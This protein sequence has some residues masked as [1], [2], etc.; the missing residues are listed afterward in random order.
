MTRVIF[1]ACRYVLTISA[2][3]LNQSCFLRVSVTF[4]GRIPANGSVA[5]KILQEPFRTFFHHI[6]QLALSWPE[7]EFCSSRSSFWRIRPYKPPCKADRTVSCTHIVPSPCAPRNQCIVS[8]IHPSD[9]FIRLQHVFKA[10]RT[11]SWAMV[12]SRLFGNRAHSL[13]VLVNSPAQ[14]VGLHARYRLI[15]KKHGSSVYDS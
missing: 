11:V 9:Y 6:G 15:W 10:R 12:S 14:S 13:L 8:R 7:W 1:S 5:L 3:N 2:R 4:T